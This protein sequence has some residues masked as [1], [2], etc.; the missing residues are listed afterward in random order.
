MTV[1]Q[2]CTLAVS[3]DAPFDAVVADLADPSAHPRWAREFFAGDAVPGDE[4]GEVRVQVPMMGGLVRMRVDAVR[5]LGVLDLYL[6]PEGAPYGPAV[7]IRVLH[8]GDG[9]DV[10]FTLS[11]APGMPQ[12]AWEAGTASMARELDALKDRL[13]PRRDGGVPQPG[14]A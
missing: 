6:A 12:E 14:E 5:E 8:N 13:E 3:I 7:P 4:P 9:A 1:T 10:L 11:R 2:T